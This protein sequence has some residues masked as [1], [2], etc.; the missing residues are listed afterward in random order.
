MGSSQPPQYHVLTWSGK[1]TVVKYQSVCSYPCENG[2]FR[3]YIRERECCW[4]CQ[5]CSGENSFSTGEV[6]SECEEGYSPNEQRNECTV[7]QIYYLTWSNPWSIVIVIATGLGLVLT[8]SLAVVFLLFHK[9][10]II[11]ASSRELSAI[12]LAGLML[13]FLQP[14]FFLIQPSIAIC[15]IR[16]FLVGFCF[17]V[18]FSPLL[19][20]TNRLHRIFN[21]SPE[22]L[23]TKPRFI[24]PLS[25]VIITF[26]LISVQVVIAITWLSI[27]HPSTTYTYNSHTTELKCGASSDV[28]LIVSLGYNLLLLILSTYFAFL[29]RKIPENFNEAK[30]INVT[31]YT[32]IIIWLDFIPTYFGTIKLGSA[33][34]TSSLVIAI[35]M[36]AYTTLCCLFA[37]KVFHLILQLTKKKE[38]VS[39]GNVFTTKSS[40]VATF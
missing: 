37:P 28:G 34:Q 31:L 40:V 39:I 5:E 13:C 3:D 32:I 2:S 26:L 8:A 29:A 9:H 30:F 25:Q 14:F 11:K 24:G 16:R 15:T 19:V 17:A 20:K 10:K 23:K 35:I 12:L 7:N 21:R 6:C 22:Q 1:V 38:K 27:E 36:S 4:T 33:Y 18:S